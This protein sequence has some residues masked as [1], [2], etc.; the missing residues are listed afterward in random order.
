MWNADVGGTGI[1]NEL[2]APRQ[3]S[4]FAKVTLGSQIM[5]VAVMNGG[6][7]RLLALGGMEVSAPFGAILP[8]GEQ[9]P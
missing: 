4:S 6:P 7:S 2:P 5:F 3:S 9:H 8:L 1:I